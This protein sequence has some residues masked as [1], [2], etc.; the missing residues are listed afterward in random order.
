MVDNINEFWEEFNKYADKAAL[1]GK[2]FIFRGVLD[3]NY[4]LIPSIGRKT[5]NNT[6]ENIQTLESNI[7]QEF[8][9]LAVPIIKK[10]PQNDFEWLFLAQHYGL[11]TRLLDWSTNPMVGLFFAVESE[12]EKDGAFHVIE[13][14]ISD[15]YEFLDYRKADFSDEAK[16]SNLL[17]RI[18]KFQD[19]QGEVF[20]IRPK[21]S[22]QRYLNQKS[23]FSCSANPFE[24]ISIKE[25]NIL[26]IKREWK[27]EIRKKLKMYGISH[28]FVYPGLEGV[29]KEIRKDIFE[30]VETGKLRI[31]TLETQKI[32]L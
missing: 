10:I 27:P 22:E 23:V 11:P 26:V 17:Y 8:K 9:R 15:D 7:L 5:K 1:F 31:V 28:S 32:E 4:E 3:A 12:D 6:Y 24:P 21:Y 30:P 25:H 14:P 13:H 2:S 16:A 29:A 20:F 18:I 19:Y